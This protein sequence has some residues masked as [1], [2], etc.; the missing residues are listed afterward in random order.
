MLGW[1]E[2]L[3]I[4]AVLL[5]VMGPA[6]LPEMAKALGT[7][8]REFQQAQTTL[9]T[10]TRNL[11]AQMNAAVNTLPPLSQPALVSPT[12][13]NPILIA[14]TG[15]VDAQPAVAAAAS[16]LTQEEEID[17]RLGEVA[18]TLGID[19]CGKTEEQ[20]RTEIMDAIRGQEKEKEVK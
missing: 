16:A 10:T 6:K 13:P 1:P 15:P 14:A 18:E 12:S 20:L 4:F 9:E 8:M 7:A 3:L 2:V 5:L 17:P 11:D 19:A